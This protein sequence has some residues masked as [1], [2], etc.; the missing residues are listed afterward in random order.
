MSEPTGAHELGAENT[1]ETGA[2]W[3]SVAQACAALNLSE[4]TV[5]KRIK[6]GEIEAMRVALDKGGTA[7]RIPQRAVYGLGTAVET[8]A[9]RNIIEGGTEAKETL[10]EGGT[11][12]LERNG[13]ETESKVERERNTHAIETEQPANVSV[14]VSTPK[15]WEQRE[16]DFRDEIKFLRDQLGEANR[17]AAELRAALRKSLEA[18]PKAITSG[19]LGAAVE[20]P[21]SP[22]KFPDEP[23]PAQHA[24]TPQ[25]A[26]KAAA[27]ALPPVARE[28]RPL[29]KVIFGIR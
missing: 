10:K 7:Y 4:K 2:N 21:I 9:Q 14:P 13:T 1:T 20:A 23:T 6:A 18:M 26:Q 25:N 16:A 19:T 15:E 27:N 3:L 28:M 17:N 29:W 12:F 5:R 24:E 11:E 8:E 22:N